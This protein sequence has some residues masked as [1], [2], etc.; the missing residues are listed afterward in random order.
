LADFAKNVPF[1]SLLESG[2]EQ[3]TTAIC[4]REFN[5]TVSA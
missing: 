3:A 4:D 5:V 1:G 2:I